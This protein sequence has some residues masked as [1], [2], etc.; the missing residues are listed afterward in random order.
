[1]KDW[2]G[3]I[4]SYKSFE[5]ERLRRTGLSIDEIPDLPPHRDFKASIS[6]KGRINLIGEIKFASP[7]EGIIRKNMDPSRIGRIYEEAGV[8]AISFLTERRFFK[9][10]IHRLPALKRALSVPI[11]RKDFIFDEIQLRESVLFGADAVLLIAGVLSEERLRKLLFYSQELGLDS[12]VEVHDLPDLEKALRCGAEIIGINN[13]NLKT[14]EVNL[15]TTLDLAPLI[16]EDRILV[17]E[18]GISRKEEIRLLEGVGVKAFLVGTSIM[19]SD[20]MRKKI[21]ELLG[22]ENG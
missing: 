21:K 9:G 6:R 22:D 2:I 17:S 16:P 5:V 8:S 20:D 3:E 14:L 13:R 4:L 12:M 15:K 11:L 10:D 7:S 18:S 1:M 19:R